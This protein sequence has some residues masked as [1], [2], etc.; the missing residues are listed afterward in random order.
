MSNWSAVIVCWSSID[1]HGAEILPPK[2]DGKALDWRVIPP[3]PDKLSPGGACEFIAVTHANHFDPELLAGALRALAPRFAWE[4]PEEV[5]VLWKNEDAERYSSHP[6]F[7][8]DEIPSS[9]P[10]FDLGPL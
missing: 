10:A 6:V 1:S 3:C 7:G 5:E 9:G 8:L 2:L 4:C